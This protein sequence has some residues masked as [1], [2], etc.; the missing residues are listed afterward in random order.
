MK[1]IVIVVVAL[2]VAGCTG[3]AASSAAAPVA[4]TPSPTIDVEAPLFAAFSSHLSSSA[5]TIGPLILKFSTD[6]KAG[7][8]ALV[9]KDA[10]KILAWSK[11]ESAWEDANTPTFCYANVYT[12]WDASRTHA[13][14]AATLALAGKYTRSAAELDM[15]TTATAS[16]TE[17]LAKVAC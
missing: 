7:S 1:G 15:M 9:K 8:V 16:L 11:A 4:D 13:E 14:A 12:I 10:A 3:G 6:A 2:A 5:G 17:Q